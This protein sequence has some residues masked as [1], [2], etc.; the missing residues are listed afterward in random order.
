MN[1]KF[2]MAAVRVW[3]TEVLIAG[4]NYFVL[5]RLVH[6]PRWGELAAH[7][8]GMATRIVCILVLAY[9]LLRHVPAYTT[10]DT[11][12]AGAL[13]LV[14]ALVFEWGGSALLR[15]PVHEILAGWRITRGYM[16]P[17]VLLT[18]LS[19]PLL[20][21]LLLHPGRPAHAPRR[22]RVG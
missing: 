18:Y 22:I 14:L 7:Q 3:L 21:G 12:Q 17:Y 1:A 4:F 2:L 11:I 20:A 16:W 10:R 15:R 8:I 19:A 13:W 5:M 6:E 9:L